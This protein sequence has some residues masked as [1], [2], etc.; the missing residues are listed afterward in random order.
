MGKPKNEEAQ[1]KM[2]N[3]KVKD[4]QA[5]VGL[6]GAGMFFW[7][8]LISA[9]CGASLLAL[10]S[11]GVYAL[12]VAMFVGSIDWD[13]WRQKV[14]CFALCPDLLL[15]PVAL[16]C[17]IQ[18]AIPATLLLCA[19]YVLTIMMFAVSLERKNLKERVV[20]F[21]VGADILLVPIVLI[22]ALR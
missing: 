21:M 4:G 13:N 7:V 15:V 14:R 11:C 8:G 10:F 22:C 2:R 1:K 6:I 3:A 20:Y 16:L 17:A 9:I 12:Y 18:G 5:F 19:V